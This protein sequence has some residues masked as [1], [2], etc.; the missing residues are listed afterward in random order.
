MRRQATTTFETFF[1]HAFP[2]VAR[3][4]GRIAGREAGEDAAIEALARAY[5]RWPR[6]SSMDNPE[7]WVMH[8]A[9]NL[10][11]DQIRK[12]PVYP[13]QTADR[14]I[15]DKV[16]NEQILR[17]S[18]ATLTRRQ[19]QVVALRY[20]ADMPEEAVAKTLDVSPGAVKTHLHRALE[21]LRISLAEPEEGDTNVVRS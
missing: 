13:K 3:V 19:R 1:R 6:V 4:A 7:A 21:R 5:A 15:E 8:V 14:D 10:A 18:I 12:K 16:I 9:T 2:R 17:G 11:I 20:L